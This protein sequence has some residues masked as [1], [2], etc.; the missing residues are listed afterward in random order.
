MHQENDKVYFWDV[1]INNYILMMIWDVLWTTLCSHLKQ[2]YILLLKRWQRWLQYDLQRVLQVIKLLSCLAVYQHLKHTRTFP[3]NNG[4]A[5][6]RASLRK[7]HIR[8]KKD[9]HRS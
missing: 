6:E 2:A 4:Q 7:R 1:F 5:Q 8:Q 9:T 3:P